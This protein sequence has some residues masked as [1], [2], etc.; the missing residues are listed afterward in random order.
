LLLLLLLL[1]LCTCC[2]CCAPVIPSFNQIVRAFVHVLYRMHQREGVRS[3]LDLSCQFG[4]HQLG[5]VLFH[6]SATWMS[7]SI[8]L[9]C[10]SHVEHS[11]CSAFVDMPLVCRWPSFLLSA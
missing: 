8:V 11:L 5:G 4:H 6:V 7:S 3:A 9:S 2:S 1:L 10:R